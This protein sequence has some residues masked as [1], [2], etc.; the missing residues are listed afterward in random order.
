M[1]IVDQFLSPEVTGRVLS[2]WRLLVL[3]ETGVIPDLFIQTET[4]EPAKQDAEVNLFH[5]L[6]VAG[7]Q[8]RHMQQHGLE[9]LFRRDRWSAGVVVHLAEN[10]RQLIKG[11]INHLPDGPQGV[12]LGHK[13]FRR[14]VDEQCIRPLPKTMHTVS[15]V[16]SA[17]Y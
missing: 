8:V 4:E 14:D 3:A 6:K 7:N 2:R 15:I 5:Q 12:I 9:Q 17:R 1:S 10:R 11:S 16:I 13:G